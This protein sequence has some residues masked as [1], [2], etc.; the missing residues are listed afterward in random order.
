MNKKD[1][2][3]MNKKGLMP[4]FLTSK[5]SQAVM[6]IGALATVTSCSLL[7]HEKQVPNQ[8]LSNHPFANKK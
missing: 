2:K 5:I 1:E 8:L 4:K 3:V 7:F 6:S